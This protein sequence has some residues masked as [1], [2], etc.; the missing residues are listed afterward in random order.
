MSTL[1]TVNKSA[2]ERNSLESCLSVC[3]ADA[4]VLLIEDAVVSALQGTSVSDQIKQATD[5]GIKVFALGEDIKAR[6]LSEKPLMDQITLV[7]Y[8][9]F[10]KLTT[11][12]DRVQNW[13]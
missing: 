7:D 10:V 5:K 1:H 9:G 2:F 13:L 12:N 8:S 3:K 11:E 4:S 6:G